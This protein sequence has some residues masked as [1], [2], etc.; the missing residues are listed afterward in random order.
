MGYLPIFVDLRGRDC[1]VIGGDGLAESR[2]NALRRAGATVTVIASELT[3]GLAAMAHAGVINWTPRDYI[4]NDMDGRFMAWV[5][6]TDREVCRLAAK[7]ARELGIMINVADVT[8][9]SDFITPAVVKRGDVQV[10]ITTGGA[11]PALARRLREQLEEVIGPEYGPLA[12]LMR[13][14]RRWLKGHVNDALQRAKIC[15]GLVA[16][17][18]IG[19][20]GR[21]D[22]EEA[23]RLVR[24]HLGVGLDELG[25][26]MQ[27]ASAVSQNGS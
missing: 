1:V 3:T 5:A 12:E 27:A 14:V 11:S 9:L 21:G 15:A 20:F 17:E 7:D 8:A 26:K 23:E 16:P 13:C 19:A 18:L 2:V 4:A 24:A 25:F 10:A 6:T 22:V